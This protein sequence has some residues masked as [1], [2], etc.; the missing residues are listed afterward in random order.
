MRKYP[1][2]IAALMLLCGTLAG[3]ATETKR[4]MLPTDTIG[5]KN[6]IVVG[7]IISDKSGIG[8]LVHENDHTNPSAYI[9][10]SKNIR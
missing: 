8:I 1:G 7:R 6:A 3:C 10:C 4:N 2:R 5:K 9:V